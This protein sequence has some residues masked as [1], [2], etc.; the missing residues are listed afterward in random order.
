MRKSIDFATSNNNPT[1]FSKGNKPKFANHVLKEEYNHLKAKLVDGPNWFRVVPGMLIE[2]QNHPCQAKFAVLNLP[3][4]KIA[5]SPGQWGVFGHLYR[6]AKTNRPDLLDY[7]KPCIPKEQAAF[8]VLS[9]TPDSTS[10]SLIMGSAYDGSR[11][12]AP[13]YIHEIAKTLTETDETGKLIDPLNPESGRLICVTKTTP[14]I[15][16][17]YPSY[18][19][20]IGNNP[21]PLAP[22]IQAL[23][24][25][26]FEI[27]SSTPI[28]D[29]IR[30][31][32]EEEQ[33]EAIKAANI[34][35]PDMI[36]EAI[37]FAKKK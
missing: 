21:A 23:S 13:G 37:A 5:I 26:D 16:D 15:K 25:E 18:S 29:T 1:S 31:M 28:Q 27:L 14:Q 12:G 35:P 4:S 34:C 30:L 33:I 8:W 10:L 7:L 3:E 32:T 19:V 9:G 2:G 11:G 6:Y 17:A 24:N 36:G 20:K 22:Y